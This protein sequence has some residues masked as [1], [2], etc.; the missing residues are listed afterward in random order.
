MRNIA[1]HILSLV[2]IMSFLSGRAQSVQISESSYLK[3]FNSIETPSY[4]TFRGGIGNIGNLVYEANFSSEFKASSARYPNFGFVFTGQILLRMYD[5]FS[6]PVKTPSYMPR[7]TLFYHLPE[8]VKQND[9]FLFLTFGHHSNGQDGLLLQ[10]D[11]VSLNT[12]NG[13]FALNYFSG[14]Y[15]LC[16][17]NNKSFDPLNSFRV[18]AQYQI[19]HDERLKDKYGNIRF[20][21]ALKS[22]CKLPFEVKNIFSGEK[23]KPYFT[24][25][26]NLTWIGNGLENTPTVDFKRLIVSYTLS[27]QPAFISSVELFARYYYGQDYYNIQ[28]QRTLNVLQAGVLIRDLHF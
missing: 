20:Y 10:A 3:R 14:G 27:Y 19:I 26:L 25:L 16:S 2:L 4:I 11:S 28:F 12:D 22:T 5:Q 23:A 9:Q 1:C 24:G 8:P 17:K 15:E 7:A 13:S 21:A 18:T 6:H